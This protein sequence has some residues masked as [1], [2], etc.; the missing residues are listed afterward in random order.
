MASTDVAAGGPDI[1]R[2]AALL[3]EPAR[4]RVLIAL[5]DGRALPSSVL[6]SEAGVAAS[7]MSEHLARLL[8][9]GLVTAHRQGRAR[10]YRLAGPDVAHVLEAIARI[11]PPRPV[12]S[13]REGTRAH[14]VRE[15]RTCYNHLAGRLGVALMAAL[16]DGGLLEGG[17]GLHHDGG[18]DRLSAPGHDVSYRLTPRGREVIAGLGVD[19]DAVLARPRAVRYCVD[20]SEQH[21]HLAGPLGA[22]LT[23][24]LFAL[25]WL[26]RAGYPRAVRLTDAGRAGLRSAVGLAAP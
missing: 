1:A 17:D 20:W 7:T 5:A 24:R 4:A 22:A 19:V 18:D 16:L 25:G 6:A 9:A 2:V 26:R 14:A 8:D 13:L 11:A 23:G 3:G 10:Y 12:R 15:A 21:H